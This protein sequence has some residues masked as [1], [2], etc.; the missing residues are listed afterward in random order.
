MP[1]ALACCTRGCTSRPAPSRCSMRRRS[2][3]CSLTSITMPAAAIP[4]A[5]R[6]AEHWR[7]GRFSYI[8]ALRGLV[9]GQQALAEIGADE[10]A[11]ICAGGDRS[12]L[13]SALLSFSPASNQQAL[14]VNSERIDY[15]IGERPEWRFPTAL[16]VG[17]A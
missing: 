11:V 6:A 15:L 16:A 1:S 10:A 3:P 12:A 8:P 9:D 2:L 7:G 14:G 13:A 17:A 4:F 5:W